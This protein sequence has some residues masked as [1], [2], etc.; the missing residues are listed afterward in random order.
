MSRPSFEDWLDQNEG[1]LRYQYAQYLAEKKLDALVDVVFWFEC[2]MTDTER[3]NAQIKARNA[4]ETWVWATYEE[5]C[6]SGPEREEYEE[7]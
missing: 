3:I 7:R 2:H 5:A 1:D 6:A 4:W